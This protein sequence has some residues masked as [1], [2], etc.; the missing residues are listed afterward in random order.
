MSLSVVMPIGIY[1]AQ[2]GMVQAQR[3]FE[4]AAESIA[5]GIN[6]YVNPADKYVATGWILRFALQK[7]R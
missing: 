1:S 5:S 7:K 2:T 3:T 4:K 6:S